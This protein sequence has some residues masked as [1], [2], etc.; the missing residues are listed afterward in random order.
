MTAT[1]KKTEKEDTRDNGFNMRISEMVSLDRA[2][3][4]IRNPR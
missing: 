2:I 3:K 1:L 4:D